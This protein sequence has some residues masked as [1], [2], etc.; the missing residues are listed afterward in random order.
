MLFLRKGTVKRSLRAATATGEAKGRSPQAKK[1][2]TASREERILRERAGLATTQPNGRAA[3]PK[4]GRQD[5][6]TGKKKKAMTTG[7]E[8]GR[9]GSWLRIR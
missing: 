9:A 8:G 7:G 3:C 2:N 5:A 1:R 6:V 4:G